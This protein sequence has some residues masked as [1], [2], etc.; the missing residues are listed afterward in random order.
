MTILNYPE[1]ANARTMNNY[2]GYSDPY[3][4][5]VEVCMDELR[6]ME[7]RNITP[8]TR[9]QFHHFV[10]SRLMQ[11][12]SEWVFKPVPHQ[13]E[14]IRAWFDSAAV[15][16]IP[17]MHTLKTR[18]EFKP[19]PIALPKV[20]YA[21]RGML[22]RMFKYFRNKKC[23][24]RYEY[25][26]SMGGHQVRKGLFTYDSFRVREVHGM[27]EFTLVAE[28]LDVFCQEFENGCWEFT[29]LGEMKMCNSGPYCHFSITRV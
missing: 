3:A 17:S 4:V 1:A 22:N 8:A 25:N 28:G 9:E 7:G 15:G 16:T 5:L 13:S 20:E 6:E 14:I 21:T 10:T 11:L 27:M 12:E 19:P 26:D 18:F 23:L 2:P 29:G 24:V